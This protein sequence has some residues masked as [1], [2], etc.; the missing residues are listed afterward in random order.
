M[1]YESRL[2]GLMPY[3][4]CL[5]FWICG[6]CTACEMSRTVPLNGTLYQPQLVIHGM[7]SPLSGAAAVVRYNEPLPGTKA[8]IP[9]LPPLEVNLLR[10][11]E[12]FLSFAEDS[13][14]SFRIPPAELNWEEGRDYALEVR[15]VG[16]GEIYVSGSSRLPEAPDIREAR[17]E[18]GEWSANLYSLKLMLGPVREPVKAMAVY[19]ILLD[20]LGRPV[21]PQSEWDSQKISPGNKIRNGVQYFNEEVWSEREVLLQRSRSYRGATDEEYFL[22]GEID[23]YVSYLSPELTAFV[24]DMEEMLDSGE[25]IFQVARPLYSNFQKVPGV[26]GLYNEVKMRLPVQ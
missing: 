8:D 25:D 14:G 3:L 19:P 9:E 16:T 7:A 5:G 10:D 24:R 23:L 6:L 21:G 2:R 26:F 17:A 12:R 22:S 1:K 4:L 20:S 11:G 15:D 18:S 13:T